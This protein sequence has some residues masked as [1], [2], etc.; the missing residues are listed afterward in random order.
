M[1]DGAIGDSDVG[2]CSNMLVSSICHQHL[3]SVFN[4]R[5]QYRC[6]LAPSGQ[7]QYKNRPKGNFVNY[8]VN[9]LAEKYSPCTQHLKR[10]A[11]EDQS[12]KRF[13]ERKP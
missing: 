5:H 12:N 13:K 8:R 4:I 3:E 2:D 1:T 6:N 7:W 11:S 10:K 9:T